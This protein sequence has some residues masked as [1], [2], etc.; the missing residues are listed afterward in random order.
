MY[1]NTLVEAE[2]RMKSGRTQA[3]LEKGVKRQT[4]TKQEKNESLKMAKNRPKRA[5][6]DTEE[7]KWE[8]LPSYGGKK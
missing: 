8:P 5:K 1:V 6:I 7:D 2:D 4:N 3:L